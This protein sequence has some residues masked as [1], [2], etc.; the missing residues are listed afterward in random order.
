MMHTFFMYCACLFIITL[1]L[2]HGKFNFAKKTT[3]TFLPYIAF[4]L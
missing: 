2:L 4:L 1:H 3:W